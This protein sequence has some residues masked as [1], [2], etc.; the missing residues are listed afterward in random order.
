M[1]VKKE[2]VETEIYMAEDGTKFRNKNECYKYENSDCVKKGLKLYDED[3][4]RVYD[5]LSAYFFKA[6]K[7]EDIKAFVEI[8]E[9]HSYVT[10]GIEFEKYGTY[11][12]DV[13]TD[14]YILL[15]EKIIEYTELL[16]IPKD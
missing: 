15:E 3:G 11:F 7:E 13:Y 4:N 1:T 8:S 5:I 6:E 2:L 10:D 14:A 9:S 12:Y 16:N